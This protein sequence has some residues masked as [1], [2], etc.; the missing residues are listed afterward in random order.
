VIDPEPRERWILHFTHIDN[1]PAIVADGRLSCD[2]RAR[3]GRTVVEVGDAD[4]KDV[5]RRRPVPCRPGGRVGDYVPFYFGPRSPMMF[6]IAAI[7]ATARRI[8][9]PVAT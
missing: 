4:I 1:L 6:R 2:V 9:T 3:L 5:R 8:D 7:T